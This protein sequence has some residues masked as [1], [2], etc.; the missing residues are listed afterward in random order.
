MLA[1]RYQLKK[2]AVAIALRG[3]PWLFRDQMS[4]AA[5]LF[6]DGDLL[7]LVD[8]SNQV[9]GYGVYEAE[10]AIAIRML[11][12]GADAPD[13]AW[14]R[15]QLGA[16]L[17]KRAS[18]AA[19]TDAIRLVNGESDGLAAIVVDRFADTIVVAS[20]S[21]GVDALAHY[22]AKLLAGAARGRVAL[23]ISPA[24][25]HDAAHTQPIEL[26]RDQSFDAGMTAPI[27]VT[28]P[29]GIA[30]APTPPP[31]AATDLRAFIGGAE[32]V[33]LRPARRR[34]GPVVAQR[35]LCGSAPALV[36][37]HEDGRALAVDL[38]GGHKTGTYLDLRALR[39]LLAD[40]P[41]ANARVL[42]L[43]AYTGMLGMS[44]ELAGAR[45]ITEVDQSARALAFA[46]QHH[47]IDPAQHAYVVADVFEWLPA[48]PDT[49]Q[50]DLVI[51]DPPAMASQQ[52]QIPTALA[53]YRKL[54]KAAAR[55]VLP[56]GAVV[57]ACC[58][59][60][61]ERKL[62]EKTV[63]EA[64][65]PGFILERDVPPEPDHPVGFAQADYLK[66]HLWRR[67]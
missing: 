2:D 45:S 39:R 32:H 21:Q 64:L 53:A 18:V 29:G 10:G 12:R 43:F 60:R 19:R 31:A 14:V 20:Y 41:L 63:R 35:V 54:Y 24:G 46:Q 67:R 23:D 55:H 26:P 6:A 16:A 25:E 3:H 13:A 59:S 27:A 11:R 22:I 37:I 33:V 58:T 65:G 40:A 36:T 57:A 34:R 51:C 42:N 1:R 56:G 62:F 38:E 28:R 50:Y 66:V 48:L 52:S 4:S 8:G 61:I 9:I 15:A 49:E 30:R 5:A 17:A 7:R 47:A 44:V